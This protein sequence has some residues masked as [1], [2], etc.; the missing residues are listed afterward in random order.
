[1]TNPTL[2]IIHLNGTSRQMLSDGYL[3][4]HRKLLEAINAFSEIEFNPRDYY[5]DGPD[6]WPRAREQRRAMRGDLIRVRDY[7]EA[8]LMHLGE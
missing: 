1:M 6:R 4:A 3:N 5:V 8:H 7:L 2:P